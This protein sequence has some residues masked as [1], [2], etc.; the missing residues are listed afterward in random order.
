MKLLDL[1][2]VLMIPLLWGIN[3]VAIKMS[4]TYV[5]PI[6]LLVV[7]FMLVALILCPVLKGIPRDMWGKLFWISISIGSFYYATMYI[8][9]R[10]VPAGEACII[11]Q[12]QVPVAALVAAWALKEKLKLKH[13]VGIFVALVGVVVT[14]GM[15]H[16]MGTWYGVILILIAGTSTGIAYVQIRCLKKVSGLQVNAA[17]ALMAVPQLF[18]LSMFWDP[19]GYSAGLHAAWQGWAAL[20]Y[21]VIVSSILCYSLWFYL[22]GKYPVHKVVPFSLL[23]PIFAV[24]AGNVVLG[25]HVAIHTLLGCAITML[26]LMWVIAKGDAT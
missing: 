10:T 6:V 21:S 18:V 4:V 9:M 23:T 11:A 13:V 19:H 24:I 16:R 17:A 5:D 25:E 22:L 3:F 15:P 1:F 26:G 2:Y 14:I 12:V 20:A 7:R 8:G